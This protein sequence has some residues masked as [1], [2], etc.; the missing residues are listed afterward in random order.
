MIWIC[1]T[2]LNAGL[3]RFG[4]KQKQPL[5]SDH[6]RLILFVVGGIGMADM[7]AAAEAITAASAG[8]AAVVCGGN[9]LLSPQ[10]VLYHVL[11]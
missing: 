8:C 9:T 4:L 7:R 11:Q 6:G 2:L 10:D 1:R 5:P 3:G